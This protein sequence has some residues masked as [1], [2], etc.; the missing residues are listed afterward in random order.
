MCSL[1][2]WE[3]VRE[4]AGSR[5]GD[6]RM[7]RWAGLTPLRP[8]CSGRTGQSGRTGLRPTAELL[9]ASRL[10]SHKD[11]HVAARVLVLVHQLVREAAF[12]E[13]EGLRET[14]VDLA[15]YDHVV[16]GLALLVVG[17]V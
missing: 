3:R 2:L 6:R 9:E 7:H 14:R 16:G 10:R 1:S 15:G 12:V 13:G 5:C 8:W 11:R 17:E 4:R